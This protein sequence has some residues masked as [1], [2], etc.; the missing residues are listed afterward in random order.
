MMVCRALLPL[1]FVVAGGLAGPTPSRA[2]DAPADPEGTW[3]GEI[4][5]PGSPLAFTVSLARSEAGD[6][7]GTVDIPSQ[8]AEQEPLTGIRVVEDS[9]VFSIEG[10]PGDPT[11]RGEVG[12]ERAALE[13]DFT[14][15]SQTFPF[16]LE[17]AEAVDLTA[18]LDGLDAWMAEHMDAWNVPGLGLAVVKDG[19]VAHLAGYGLRDVED[20]LPVTEETLFAIGSST[21]AFTTSLLGTFVDDGALDWE[22][23]VRAH[24]PEFA[25]A[26]T[27]VAEAMTVRDLVTHRSGLPRH[28]AIWYANPELTRAEVLERLPHLPPTEPLRAAWQYNNLMY[29]VAGHLMER[30]G[31]ASWEELIR[32][33]LLDPLGMPR[34]GLSVRT[35]QSDPDHALPYAERNDSLVRIDFRTIDAVGPAGSINSSAEEMAEW[36]RLHLA[37][38][39]LD[40]RTILEQGTVEAL[41]TPAMAIASRPSDPAFGVQ[42]YALGWF[43]DSYRGH[44]RVHHGG[45]IDGFSAMVALFPHDELGIVVLTNKNGT[46]LAEFAARQVA[47]RVLELEPRDWS[48][49]ALAER[50]DRRARTDSVEGPE[51]GGARRGTPGRRGD[52][53]VPRARRVRGSVSSS[54]VRRADRVRR[55]GPEGRRPPAPPLLRPHLRPRARPLRRVRDP[56]SRGAVPARRTTRPVRHGV[57]RF[58][59]R[60]RSA[61]RVG[62]VGGD[63]RSSS[64]QPPH[65]SRVSRPPHRLVRPRRP[66]H[67]GTTP[68]CAARRHDPRSALLHSRPRPRN[69]LHARG[70]PPDPSRVRGSGRW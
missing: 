1:L 46:P 65:R 39:T 43:V 68:G 57:R 12:P 69:Q 56:R 24:L 58:R 20:S 17:R 14:Q 51:A 54:R 36:L 23:R 25:L 2:Q 4:A 38:G 70:G 62:A 41:Q 59:R 40:G 67:R 3:R 26:D 64:G 19:E 32:E 42:S 28:D 60:G 31:E 9:V 35:S 13:G 29:M 30:V 50:D 16:A 27:A 55:R 22:D 10:V 47:D 7:S 34:S 45:N 6:W 11:F 48:G 66:D 33:R 21:K 44:F 49:E 52:D 8:G 5:V 37:E 15:G 61:P 63:L 18:A 53:P